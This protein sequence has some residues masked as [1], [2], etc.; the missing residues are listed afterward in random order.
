MSAK[1]APDG[2]WSDC[3]AP[4]PILG[5]EI[6]TACGGTIQYSLT[7]PCALI[8]DEMVYFCLPICQESCENDP[9]CSCL[10]ARMN[11]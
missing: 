6:R 5:E 4:R 11:Q 2:K 8:H 10:A 1:F 9:Q 7:T 3:G